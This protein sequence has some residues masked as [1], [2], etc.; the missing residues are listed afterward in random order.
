MEY[1]Q[2][3][4]VHKQRDRKKERA[5]GRRRETERKR[6]KDFCII[7]LHKKTTS[8]VKHEKVKDISYLKQT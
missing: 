4:N 6:T 5:G 8:E 2:E 3:Q 1:K 7:C